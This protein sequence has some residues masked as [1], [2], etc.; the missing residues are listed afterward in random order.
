LND[1]GAEEVLISMKRE[2]FVK[3]VVAVTEEEDELGDTVIFIFVPFAKVTL[4]AIVAF[5]AMATTCSARTA[6]Q[7]SY[8]SVKVEIDAL[9][10]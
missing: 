7:T 2:V 8:T 1:G 9:R 10:K 4:T 5:L 3:F 6:H